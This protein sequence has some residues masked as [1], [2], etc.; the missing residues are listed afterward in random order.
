MLRRRVISRAP[1]TVGPS[2]SLPIIQRACFLVSGQLPSL[3]LRNSVGGQEVQA[4]SGAFSQASDAQ[5]GGI[6]LTAT[7]NSSAILFTS[8]TG[9]A[10]KPTT[11]LTCAARV[12][13]PSAGWAGQYLFGRKNSTLGKASFGLLSTGGLI[14]ASGATN[15]SGTNVVTGTVTVSGTVSGSIIVSSW[16]AGSP[17][18]AGAS[19]TTVS[20]FANESQ[21]SAGDN[22]VLATTPVTGATTTAVMTITGDGSTGDVFGAITAQVKA[23]I[24]GMTVTINSQEPAAS[25]HASGPYAGP[26]LTWMFNNAGG[27]LLLVGVTLSEVFYGPGTMTL[28]PVTYGGVTMTAVSGTPYSGASSNDLTGIYYLLNPPTGNNQ[29]NVQFSTSSGFVDCMAGAI[30]FNSGG[31]SVLLFEASNQNGTTD[32]AAVLVVSGWHT[33]VGRY[34]S[35]TTVDLS[36]FDDNGVK[37]AAASGTPA[38]GSIAWDTSSAL[39]LMQGMLGSLDFAVL[40][41]SYESDSSITA[42]IQRRKEIFSAMNAGQVYAPGGVVYSQALSGATSGV[43][44]AMGRGRGVAIDSTAQISL[45]GLFSQKAATI[46]NMMLAK[47]SLVAPARTLTIPTAP[48]SGAPTLMTG[49]IARALSSATHITVTTVTKLETRALSAHAAVAPV[50]R[51]GLTTVHETATTTGAALVNLYDRMHSATTTAASAEFIRRLIRSA[52]SASARTSATIPLSKMVSIIGSARSAA[53]MG[54]RIIASSLAVAQAGGAAVIARA[55]ARALIATVQGSGRMGARLS[56]AILTAAS[57]AGGALVRLPGRTLDT[58]QALFAGAFLRQPRP[59]P[60]AAVAG[61]PTLLPARDYER[62]LA[63]SAAGSPSL[64]KQLFRSLVATLAALAGISTVGKYPPERQISITSERFKS[65]GM[66]GEKLD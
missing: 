30:S 60:T 52:D 66:I 51:R 15:T 58:A 56:S 4:A 22:F 65:S 25:G 43:P 9:Q 26:P 23:G 19:G 53:V 17:F 7:A 57:H 44:G 48:V 35:G 13:L 12:N 14:V 20:C 50:L 34:R 55:V 61:A 6:V 64:V 29:V 49:L 24:S 10:Q 8:P 39:T 45:L 18:G 36:V 11:A 21:D 37:V 31:G 40:T 27:D 41:P 3:L 2:F 47:A 38:S 5:T 46:A 59:V 16:R 32:T 1:R 63:V 28:G 33:V 42:L 54:R 62:T